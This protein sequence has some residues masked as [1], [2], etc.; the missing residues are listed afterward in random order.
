M[1][2]TSVAMPVAHDNGA[3]ITY[4][5]DT[6]S[7]ARTEWTGSEL[8]LVF[9]QEAGLRQRLARLQSLPNDWD[10]EGAEPISHRTIRNAQDVG[11]TLLDHVTLP[12]ITPN[13]GDTLTFEWESS[14]G[15]A[16]LEIGYDRYSFLMK[17][18]LDRRVTDTG[19]SNNS[20]DINSIGAIIQRTLFR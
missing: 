5:A 9:L 19:P 15:S 3:S 18:K 1:M 11:L 6:K 17:T 12:E 14:I 7:K 8:D 16:L 10:G 20:A 4:A 2:H 13:A